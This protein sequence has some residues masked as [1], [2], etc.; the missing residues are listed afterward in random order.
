MRYPGSSDSKSFIYGKTDD[1]RISNIFVYLWTKYG[2]SIR[3]EHFSAS[4]ATKIVFLVDWFYSKG[5]KNNWQQA[6]PIE[7]Y[8]NRYGPYVDLIPIIKRKFK[9]TEET[10]K[11]LFS[12]KRSVNPKESDTLDDNIKGV[13]KMVIHKTSSLDYPTFINYVYRT[14]AVRLSKKYE[15]IQIRD[16]ARRIY[17]NK[18]MKLW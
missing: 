11:T 4:R 3:R 7:W 10:H 15:I 5:N 6:T 16:I 12:L 1:G 9:I 8:F 14:P 13:C 18:N 17:G 2:P